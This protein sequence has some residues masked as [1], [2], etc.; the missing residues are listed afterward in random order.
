MPGIYFKYDFSALTVEV[1]EQHQE[2][3]IKFLTRL[4]AIT[5]GVFICSG[6]F[7]LFCRGVNDKLFPTKF[8]F[9]YISSF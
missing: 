9:L 5:G 6:L 8:N 4:A 2:S 1:L 7:R 3:F